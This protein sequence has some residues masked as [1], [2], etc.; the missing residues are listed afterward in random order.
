MAQQIPIFLPTLHFTAHKLVAN[1]LLLNPKHSS[2]SAKHI[3][4]SSLPACVVEVAMEGVAV[5]AGVGGLMSA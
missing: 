1:G 4:N 5:G 2:L 3:S